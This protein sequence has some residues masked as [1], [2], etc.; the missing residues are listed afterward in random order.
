VLTDLPEIG[1]SVNNF[2]KKNTEAIE[3]GWETN[4][5]KPLALAVELAAALG[6]Y[7]KTLTSS[8]VL[9]PVAYYLRKLG[10][11]AG[12]CTAP[13]F[14]QHR[15]A[16]RK[17]LVVSSLKSV[18]SSKTDTVLSALRTAIRD[19]DED[20]FP[21]TAIEK[22]L[23]G[24][25]ILLRFTEEELENLLTSEYGRRNTFS[26]L[27]ALYPHLNTQFKFHLDHLFPRAGFHKTK[28]RNAGFSEEAIERMQLQLNQVPNLQILEGLTNQS[29]LDTP[30]ADWIA[31]MQANSDQWAQYRTQHAIPALP[32]Y[33]MQSFEKFFE[34]RR[35]L[36]L[37]RLK[38]SL[39]V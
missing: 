14:A 7:G 19:S 9:I 1:F 2:G 36:L 39:G 32:S 26:V 12:F 3:T 33:P 29:K 15:A 27:A 21:L 4:V 6:Y 8:N 13:K 30:F 28:L 20:T 18:L 24:H 25:G 38:E 22:A 17:W 23:L 11:P 34:L 37:T 35:G 16:I 5:H 10:A 31:P